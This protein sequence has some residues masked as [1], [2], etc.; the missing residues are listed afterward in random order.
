MIALF[1]CDSFYKQVEAH[2]SHL[3]MEDFEILVKFFN[4]R[5]YLYLA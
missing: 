3:E 1:P 5:D 4:S 2:D